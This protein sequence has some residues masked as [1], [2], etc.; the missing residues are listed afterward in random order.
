M[1]CGRHVQR[2]GVQI[3][4]TRYPSNDILRRFHPWNPLVSLLLQEVVPGQVSQLKSERSFN[5]CFFFRG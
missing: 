4:E 2:V 3:G 5:D 1:M